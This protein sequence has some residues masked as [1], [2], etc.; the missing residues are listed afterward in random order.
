MLERFRAKWVPVRVKKTRQN[1]KRGLRS[2]SIGTEKAL[3][4]ITSHRQRDRILH[5]AERE[6]RLDRGDAV[7][8]GQL[9][10][11]ERLVG[12]EIGGD[13]AQ[14]IVAVSRHQV[15]LQNLLPFRDRLLEAVEIL[16]LLPRELDRDEDADM[17]PQR[18]LVDGRDVAGD[19]AAL[20]EQFD[21]A[22]ARRH[23]EPDLVGEFLHGDAAV[24]LQQRENLAVDGV[25]G[26]HWDKPC[27]IEARL[28]KYTNMGGQ[29]AKI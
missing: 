6:A 16:L 21:A 27:Q 20:F 15:A 1:K 5:L 19:D 29:S 2:D 3:V 23:R 12:R 25:E 24:G 7:E 10:L 17:Q 14:Q 13:D 22:V 18:L 26:V 8:P 4:A 9:V 28:I 11:Q